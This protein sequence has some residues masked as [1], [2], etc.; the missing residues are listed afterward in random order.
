MARIANYKDEI[1]LP[2]N[3]IVSLLKGNNGSLYIGTPNGLVI[4]PEL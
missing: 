1:D 3:A 4:V 2:H